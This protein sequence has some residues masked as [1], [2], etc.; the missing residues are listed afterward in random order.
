MGED[1]DG[2]RAA[3]IV[4]LLA[5]GG[6][7]LGTADGGVPDLGDER[8]GPGAASRCR[9]EHKPGTRVRVRPGDG[10]ATDPGR[11][12]QRAPRRRRTRG[13][14]LGRGTPDDERDDPDETATMRNGCQGHGQTP[15]PVDRWVER[16][17]GGRRLV[18]G[19]RSPA[20]IYRAGAPALCCRLASAAVKRKLHDGPA[21][22]VTLSCC[23]RRRLAVSSFSCR[24]VVREPRPGGSACSAPRRRAPHARRA[25]DARR[26]SA[27]RNCRCAICMSLSA[28]SLVNAAHAGA[29]GGPSDESLIA[30]MAPATSGPGSS[31]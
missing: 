29:T 31:S 13:P 16:R 24:E 9:V 26:A 4:G 2:K 5:S 23:F 18:R 12:Y 1:D 3:A 7:R 11:R 25:T 21:R 6:R 15:A 19:Y 14:R 28:V 10:L 8:P 22:A 20:E 17:A 30:G 27:A